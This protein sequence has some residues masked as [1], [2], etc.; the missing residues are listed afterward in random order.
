MPLI[1]R[2]A[3]TQA[4]APS[5]KTANKTLKIGNVSGKTPRRYIPPYIAQISA[6]SPIRN[7]GLPSLVIPRAIRLYTLIEFSKQNGKQSLA[8]I[9]LKQNRNSKQNSRALAIAENGH[10]IAACQASLYAE[11]LQYLALGLF[12]G[13]GNA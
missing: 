10:I 3:N 7:L 12:F 13:F 4:V 9:A 2:I 8:Q 1:R 11:H 5:P 6:R